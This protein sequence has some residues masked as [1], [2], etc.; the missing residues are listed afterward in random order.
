M[1]RYFVTLLLSVTLIA[2]AFSQDTATEYFLVGN[3]NLY[4]PGGQ[5]N[6]G[7]YPIVGY[8]KDAQPKLLI[9]GFGFGI[10][11][12]KPLRKS[13]QIKGQINLSKHTYWD[14][15]L[16]L[17]GSVNGPLGQF[18]FGSSDYAVG[19]TGA[20]HYFLGQR[21]SVGAGLGAQLFTTTLSRV[22]TL[23]DFEFVPGSITV[24]RYYRQVLPM[25]PFEWSWKG[26]QLLATIRYE[27]GL[28][29]RYKKNMAET[30]SDRFSILYFELGLR[31]K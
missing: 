8:D 10:A 20:L 21:M 6:K 13:L 23:E 25:L 14:E 17:R 15:P 26:D 29:N 22:P 4:L 30:M 11:A 2:S 1:M 7:V 24:N 9:G 16:E 12:F 31:L 27:Y 3:E 18:I 5:S 28:T 19:I